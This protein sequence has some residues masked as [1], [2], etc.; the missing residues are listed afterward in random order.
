MEFLLWK[1]GTLRPGAW[2]RGRGPICAPNLGSKAQDLATQTQGGEAR[3]PWGIGGRGRV[4]NN[5]GR[6][7]VLHLRCPELLVEE[8]AS[9]CLKDDICVCVEYHQLVVI[10]ARVPPPRKQMAHSNW[11]M[12]GQFNKGT[13]YK[14]VGRDL[15]TI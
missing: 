14:A 2:G 12:G 6:A 9:S 5:E 13:I 8:K 15:G 1:L 4:G 11:E 3:R 10:S 7:V